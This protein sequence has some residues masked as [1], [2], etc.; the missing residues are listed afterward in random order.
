MLISLLPPLFG[1]RRLIK[2]RGVFCDANA[3]GEGARCNHL[4]D[5]ETHVPSI[6]GK[7]ERI[8]SSVINVIGEDAFA[9]L[10][11][12]FHL[13][14]GWPLYLFLHFTGSRRSPVTKKRYTSTPNHFDPR[15]RVQ[16]VDGLVRRRH[17]GRGRAG[18]P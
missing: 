5:G 10:N 4:L 13:G 9:G 7:V 8:Y 11:V 18:L 17:K 16:H 2:G 1:G 14:L 3:V 12:I 6:R 15:A